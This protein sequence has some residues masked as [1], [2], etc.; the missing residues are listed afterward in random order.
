[1]FVNILVS[2]VNRSVLF[3][4]HTQRCVCAVVACLILMPAQADDVDTAQVNLVVH[5]SGFAHARGHAVANLF[6]EEDDVLKPD[7]AYRRV[8]AEIHDGS[9][10][11]IFPDL[12]YGKY[13]VSVFH[14]ENDNGTLDHNVLRFPAE[15]LGFSNGF[16]LSLFS[17][18]PSFEKLQFPFAADSGVVDITLK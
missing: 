3:S 5:A 15:P 11:I 6:R 14:D 7:K 10:A 18:M 8:S 13:A 2:A 17:G 9:A 16:R 12:S 1:M 4:A